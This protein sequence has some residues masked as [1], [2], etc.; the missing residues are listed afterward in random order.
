MAGRKPVPT[1]VKKLKGTL[2][3]CRTNKREPKLEVSSIPP[4]S[5]L[6]EIAKQEWL[7]M[8]PLLTTMGVLTEAD[9]SALA[10]YCVQYERFVTAENYLKN[11]EL[12]ITTTN[13]NEIQNT[14]LGISNRAAEL[15]RKFLTEFGLT[16]SSRTKVSAMP[17]KDGASEWDELDG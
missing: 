11:S 15:M 12:I 6:G 7:R 16:P 8:V 13:G 10:V 2:Q 3:P 9:G 17:E 5:F 14:M 1:E 4:P